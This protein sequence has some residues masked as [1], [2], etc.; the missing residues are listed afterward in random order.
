MERLSCSFFGTAEQYSGQY[1]VE[2]LGITPQDLGHLL[3]KIIH[4]PVA[5]VTAL[6]KS[7]FKPVKATY[8]H[9]FSDTLQVE[10]VFILKNA[11]IS[12]CLLCKKI[13][14]S[15]AT[16][17]FKNRQNFMEFTVTNSEIHRL[18]HGDFEALGQD[19]VHLHNV[20][21]VGYYC[22]EV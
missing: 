17:T 22:G 10:A 6:N 7:K 9:K 1:L 16:F 14:S 12:H 13:Y 5:Q 2:K 11:R 3:A 19:P 20:L 4:N 8:N 15:D 21:G 18:L